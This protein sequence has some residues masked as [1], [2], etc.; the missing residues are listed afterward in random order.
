MPCRS[1]ANESILIIA[2]IPAAGAAIVLLFDRRIVAV[3]GSAV[4]LGE[5][6]LPPI[7]DAEPLG[8]T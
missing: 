1:L 8:A 6:P 7:H 5:A 4:A 2:A 3:L